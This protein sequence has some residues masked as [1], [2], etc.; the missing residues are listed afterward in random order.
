MRKLI[1]PILI[2]SLLLSGCG[3]WLDGE[4]HSV[5]PHLSD[6]TKLPDDGVTVSSYLQVREALLDV[7]TAGLQESTFYIAGFDLETADEYM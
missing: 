3:S 7:V 1:I 5:N 2:L 4:Y 6:G